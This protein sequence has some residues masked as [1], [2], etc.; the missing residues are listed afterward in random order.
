MHGEQPTGAAAPRGPGRAAVGALPWSPWAGLGAG[1]EGGFHSGGGAG[2]LD[3]GDPT[4]QP[5]DE[6][7]GHQSFFGTFLKTFFIL[8]QWII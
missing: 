6:L 5:R 7:R 1:G 4:R 2:P 8:L 3:C